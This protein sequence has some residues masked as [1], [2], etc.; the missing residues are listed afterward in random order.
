MRVRVAAS[1]LV[2]ACFFCCCAG[3]D[4][5]SCKESSRLVAGLC[6]E[7]DSPSCRAVNELHQLHCKSI[8][9]GVHLQDTL[10]GKSSFM[11]GFLAGQS[12]CASNPAK[13]KKKAKDQ[14]NK[15][16]C[17][18]KSARI[19]VTKSK[20]Q[21][22]LKL[23]K[24]CYWRRWMLA[25]GNWKEGFAKSLQFLLNT[26]Q[27]FDSYALPIDEKPLPSLRTCCSEVLT[28][29][30]SWNKVV[31]DACCTKNKPPIKLQT[32]S[33]ICAI[34]KKKESL[35]Q[36]IVP[37]GSVLQTCIFFGTHENVCLQ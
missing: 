28:G 8:G 32:C 22:L 5:S 31:A 21:Q 34:A 15:L 24:N 18:F 7:G 19:G 23:N 33:Q 26:A 6:E 2:L 36:Q 14:K 9:E 1:L 11:K 25:T 16:A 17:I 37:K 30:L 10:E 3:T 12:K 4:S 20:K 13:E 27:L 29:G 35:V